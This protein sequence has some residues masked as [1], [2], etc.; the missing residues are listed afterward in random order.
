MNTGLTKHTRVHL[1]YAGRTSLPDIFASSNPVWGPSLV[2]LHIC[3]AAMHDEASQVVMVLTSVLATC[4]SLQA[5][6]FIA[7]AS[8][9][10]EGQA[11]F[12]SS[13]LLCK[14]TL[15]GFCCSLMDL[16]G[17]PS[18]AS[19]SLS[20]LGTPRLPCKLVLPR[21]VQ[22]LSFCATSLFDSGG[23][24]CHLVCLTQ[25]VLDSG[26]D[27]QGFMQDVPLVRGC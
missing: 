14:I 27:N 3:L 10:F 19:V 18:L 12:K 9:S 21:Q 26:M 23:T 25:I 6:L 22:N 16:S 15:E 8:Y 13:H 1:R 7:Y 11:P 24:G 2:S 5:L 4:P 20:R 17:L